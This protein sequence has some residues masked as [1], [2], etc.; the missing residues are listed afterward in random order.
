MELAS[1]PERPALLYDG[2]AESQRERVKARA[3]L[4]LINPGDFGY[5]TAVLHQPTLE[6]KTK[7][8]QTTPPKQQTKNRQ[9]SLI[10]CSLPILQKEEEKKKDQTKKKSREKKMN[11]SERRRER[12]SVSCICVWSGYLCDVSVCVLL[13]VR[14]GRED[15]DE[16]MLNV[17][18]CH[19]TY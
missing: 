10:F 8:K 14:R 9:C 13:S 18:R 7:Q 6:R 15:D 12:E 2:G 4:A 5:F 16:L 11:T 3:G 1:V 17:L 19:L